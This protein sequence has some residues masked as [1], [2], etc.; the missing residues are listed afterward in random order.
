VH[1]W[2]RSPAAAEALRSHGCVVA[3]SPRAA[4]E[5]VGAG[6]LCLAL[7]STTDAM[8][9]VVDSL[10]GA[11]CDGAILAN[12]TSGS[13][14]DGRRVARKAA[15]ACPGALYVDGAYCGPPSSVEA[16]SGQVFASCEGGA[17]AVAPGALEALDALG[18]V[19]FCAGVGAARALDYAVVD[20]AFVTLMS[21][22]AN[23]AMLEREGVDAKT[24]AKAAALR[25]AAAPAS[26]EKA[27]TRMD[28]GRDAAT[29]A[30]TPTATLGTWRN[31]WASRRP[32]LESLGA[33]TV[34]LDFVVGLLDAAGASDAATAGA[35][36]TRIQEVLRYP[37]T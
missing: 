12:L 8:D 6:G 28:A 37:R 9:A 5:S 36:V 2:N 4:L 35:D 30:E 23:A 7:L 17:A 26:M 11:A 1:V 29:Y 31:F 15:D 19:A 24:F 22:A 20:L 32:Y 27:A 10:K 18:D 16:G 33:P 3:A 13:P 25:L 34:L 14:D 21:Y